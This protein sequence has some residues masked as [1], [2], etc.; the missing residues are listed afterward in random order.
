MKS[1][2]ADCRRADRDPTNEEWGQH[3]A[4]P[5]NADKIRRFKNGIIDL[6]TTS[7]RFRTPDAAARHEFQGRN[8]TL[9]DRIDI[10]QEITLQNF[11]DRVLDSYGLIV[12]HLFHG[13][14]LVFVKNAMP[15]E[16]GLDQYLHLPLLHLLHN[17]SEKP[18]ERH[19]R[20]LV[21]EVSCE[22]E[23][24]AVV[25]MPYIRYRLPPN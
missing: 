13:P 22:D 15:A 3:G 7:L 16:P 17:I 1:V 9:W 2:F 5:V 12:T 10:T 18:I 8:W 23:Q 11:L 20:A 24:G 14:K 4:P 6:A 21:L 25:N 19:V